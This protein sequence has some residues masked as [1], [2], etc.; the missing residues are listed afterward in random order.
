MKP[1]SEALTHA[2]VYAAS[3]TV[4]SVVH[5][6]SPIIWRHYQALALPA[7]VRY[8]LWHAGDGGGSVQAICPESAERTTGFRHVG[9]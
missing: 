2:A 6:H 5:V 1:S 3:Q 9:T 7:I 8:P 4:K